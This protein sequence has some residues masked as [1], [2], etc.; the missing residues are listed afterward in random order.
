[1]VKGSN[2]QSEEFIVAKIIRTTKPDIAKGLY[3]NKRFWRGDG[4]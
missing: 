1:M 2:G 3:F 4:K